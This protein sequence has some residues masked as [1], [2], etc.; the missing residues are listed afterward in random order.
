[1]RKNVMISQEK[2]VDYMEQLKEIV[3]LEENLDKALKELSPDFGGF[4][5]EKAS[6]LIINLLKDLMDDRQE[7]YAIEGTWSQKDWSDIEYFIY[8]M[9]WGKDCRKY[10][11]IEE[12]GK[13]IYLKNEYELYDFICNSEK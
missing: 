3:H 12:N 4:H 13:K 11:I 7:V 8:D 5:N 6:S 10:P 9:N 2:F 1:M